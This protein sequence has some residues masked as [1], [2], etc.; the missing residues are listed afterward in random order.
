MTFYMQETFAQIAN[1]IFMP[2]TALLC[3][4]QRDAGKVLSQQHVLIPS[5]IV[6]VLCP[7]QSCS[8]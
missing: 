1:S 3:K 7:L 4:E 5:S 6:S 8:L 2:A